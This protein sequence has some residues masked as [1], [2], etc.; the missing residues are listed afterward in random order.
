[1]V[2]TKRKGG[3]AHTA[4]SFFLQSMYLNFEHCRTHT[5]QAS[6]LLT[7]SLLLI[8][9]LHGGGMVRVGVGAAVLAVLHVLNTFLYAEPTTFTQRIVV[10]V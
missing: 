9:A 10:V 6:I 1:M 7:S 3:A 4:A 8:C 5:T 2:I